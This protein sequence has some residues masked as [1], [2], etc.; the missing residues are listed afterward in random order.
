MVGVGVYRKTQ[1]D[2]ICCAAVGQGGLRGAET[3]EW[4]LSRW[5]NRNAGFVAR[6][7]SGQNRDR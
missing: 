4:V 2:E 5:L 7:G 6:Q 1:E 3:T